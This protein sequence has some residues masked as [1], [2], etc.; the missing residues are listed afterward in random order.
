MRRARSV[1]LIPL[2]PDIDKTLRRLRRERNQQEL[3]EATMMEDE[4]DGGAI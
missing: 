4:G 3:Q 2:N 1:D